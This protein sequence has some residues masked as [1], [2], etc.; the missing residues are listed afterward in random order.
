MLL[1]QVSELREAVR[2]LEEHREP[3]SPAQRSARAR[4]SRRRERHAPSHA[5]VTQFSEENVTQSS[6]T[7]T[8]TDPSLLPCPSP[9]SPTPLI[10]PPLIPP[11][12][13]KADLAFLVF[14]EWTK[15]MKKPHAQFTPE[16]RRKVEARL[17]QGY[18]LEELFGAIRGCKASGFHQGQNG[19]G[20][21]WDDLDLICRD[22]KHVEEFGAMAAIESV[23][24]EPDVRPEWQRR[25]YQDQKS[26]EQFLAEYEAGLKAIV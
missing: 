21:K 9:L 7:A 23:L 12:S 16:R 6:R 26:Y 1:K 15:V 22:G 18:S 19:D 17:K 20:K 4:E 25:G 24:D 14:T 2:R 3:L 10:S 11:P 5:V 8:R 13:E